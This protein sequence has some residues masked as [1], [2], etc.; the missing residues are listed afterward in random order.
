MRT[1]RFRKLPQRPACTCRPCIVTS[2]IRW[3]WPLPETLKGSISHTL[4]CYANEKGFDLV[5][6]A[7]VAVGKV[8]AVFKP[9]RIANGTKDPASM[10]YGGFARALLKLL[11]Y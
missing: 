4:K 9:L 3:N 8:E 10:S 2:R 7:V 6:E 5:V 1:Q 11:K